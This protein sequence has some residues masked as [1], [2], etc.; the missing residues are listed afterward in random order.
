MGQG[1]DRASNS[2]LVAYFIM[3]HGDKAFWRCFYGGAE[4]AVR[5]DY[6]GA[7]FE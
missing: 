4:M 6:C 5:G 1:H 7:I 2:V 3:D